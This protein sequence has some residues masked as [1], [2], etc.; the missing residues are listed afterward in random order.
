MNKAVLHLPDTIYHQASKSFEKCMR[1]CDDTQV[2]VYDARLN[3]FLCMPKCLK[4]EKP[5]IPYP[6]EYPLTQIVRDVAT[7]EFA[8]AFAT[9][10][11]D[12]L[13][14]KSYSLN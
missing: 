5:L 9:F 13:F 2:V 10:L 1:Q 4:I 3:L 8:D 12:I 6:L 14:P 7:Y 11:F